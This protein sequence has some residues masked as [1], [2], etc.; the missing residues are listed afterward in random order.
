MIQ[1]ISNAT[2]A[3]IDDRLVRYG[4]VSEDADI[5]C[6]ALMQVSRGGRI[7][8]I[9][10]SGDNV[11]AML[12]L[13]PKEI[14][15]ADLN[16][17]QLYCLELRIAAF[18]QLEHQEVLKF[19]GVIP[20]TERLDVYK[21]LRLE[22]SPLCATFWDTHPQLIKEGIIHAG[23]FE[24]RLKTFSTK[25]LPL[26][27]SEKKRNQ[28][29]A[30]QT[31][32]EQASFYEQQWDTWLWRLLCKACF[33]RLAVKEAVRDP[34][35]LSKVEG[36]LSQRILEQARHAM[37]KIPAYTNPYIVYA[38][39][40]NYTP[41]ALPRYLRPY[42]FDII[43]ARLK[44]ITLVHG[45]IQTAGTGT[46]DAFNL[47]DI[48][49]YMTDAE[50]QACYLSLVERANHKARLVYWNT[51]IDREI[52]PSMYSKVKPLKEL[53]RDLYFQDKGWFYKSFSVDECV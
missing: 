33:S 28:L 14:V 45:P 46:F 51:L 11:L 5:L 35:L 20:S 22:L 52:P 27:H 53:S 39:T 31:I 13:D 44:R 19:L 48:F 42:C 23:S 32:Q 18:S 43:K 40:G 12:T 37:T 8:S 1:A 25:L 29:L 16:T 34:A 41:E 49:G 50:F 47:S 30:S 4:T 3:L 7:L 10:S 36:S 9:A 15:A 6:N 21:R 38:L 2:A 17:A 24:K 26:V